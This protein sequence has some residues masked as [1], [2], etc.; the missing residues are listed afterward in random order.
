[1]SLTLIKIFLM[2]AFVGHIICMFCDRAITYTNNGRFIFKDLSDNNKLALLFE[3]TNTKRQMF[4]MLA[5]VLSL[6]MSCFGYIALYEYINKYSSTCGII[7]LISLVL[8]MISGTA[9]HVFCGV[10]EWFYIKFDRTEKA[11]NVILE[12]FK[13]TSSTMYVC[14]IGALMFSVTLFISIVLGLTPFPKWTC[15]FN[16]IIIFILLFPFKIVGSFNLASALTFLGL[17]IT[18]CLI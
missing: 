6:I 12:F 13:K 2:V 8:L 10:V 9:H 4:S 7:L 11:R 5:G 17:F 14:F 1:M 15:I 3:N 16:V 18:L